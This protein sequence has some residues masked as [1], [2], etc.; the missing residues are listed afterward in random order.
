MYD[1]EYKKHKQEHAEK[2]VNNIEDLNIEELKKMKEF[3]SYNLEHVISAKKKPQEW[4]YSKVKNWSVRREM[5][6]LNEKVPYQNDFS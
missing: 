4:L 2:L 6:I 1:P 3:R 5:K